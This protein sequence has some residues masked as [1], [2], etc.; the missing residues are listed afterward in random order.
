MDK[1]AGSRFDIDG[2]QKSTGS[3]VFN[4]CSST[5]VFQIEV[6]YNN[7]RHLKTSGLYRYKKIHSK[8]E[9]IGPNYALVM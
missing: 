2:A 6:N 4:L 9:Q 5:T 8:G 1:T 3:Y 7:K